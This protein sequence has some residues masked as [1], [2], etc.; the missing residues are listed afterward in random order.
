LNSVNST[1]RDTEHLS[2]RAPKLRRPRY[3]SFP[4]YPLPIRQ[5][6][7]VGARPLRRSRRDGTSNALQRAGTSGRVGTSAQ[8][9]ASSWNRSARPSADRYS[10]TRFCPLCSPARGAPFVSCRDWR[11]CA[12]RVL[13]PE[14]QAGKPALFVDQA[15]QM[16]LRRSTA[17]ANP[18]FSTVHEFTYRFSLTAAAR[19]ALVTCKK[20]RGAPDGALLERRDAEGEAPIALGCQAAPHSNQVFDRPLPPLEIRSCWP[21]RRGSRTSYV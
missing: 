12:S 2:R 4:A 7:P 8:K 13:L 11:D 20:D 1:H 18:K 6:W 3:A 21:S 14:F 5:P 9:A 17:Q 16:A 19:V 10:I 15:Q